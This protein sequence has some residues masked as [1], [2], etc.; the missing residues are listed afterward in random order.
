MQG[1]LRPLFSISSLTHGRRFS[2]SKIKLRIRIS[3]SVADRSRKPKSTSAA[4]N[5]SPDRYFA[6]SALIPMQG[7]PPLNGVMNNRQIH[8]ANQHQ[9]T[10]RTASQTT[11]VEGVPQGNDTNIQK[12]Q[13]Q[14]RSQTCIPYPPGAPHRFSHAEPVTRAI[15]VNTAPMGPSP[16]P[17]GWPFSS[18][19]PGQ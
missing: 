1:H 10:C 2:I 12:Q 14:F 4:A 18:A 19:R 9:D 3:V 6:A 13:H 15:K 7:V 17:P 5:A 16:P 8:H 11:V